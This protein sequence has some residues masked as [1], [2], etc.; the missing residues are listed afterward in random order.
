MFLLNSALI[1]SVTSY[2]ARSKFLVP[3]HDA[4]LRFTLIHS[5]Q[6]QIMRSMMPETRVQPH[7]TI[8]HYNP[9]SRQHLACCIYGLLF[10]FRKHFL[11]V[12]RRKLAFTDKEFPPM[13]R[14]QFTTYRP[15]TPCLEIFSK[16]RTSTTSQ[17]LRLRIE[18]ELLQFHSSHRPTTFKDVSRDIHY[19]CHVSPPPHIYQSRSAFLDRYDVQFDRRRCSGHLTTTK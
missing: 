7:P 1:P 9:F 4:I 17:R 2:A 10:F 11:T 6:Y 5:P 15:A 14:I 18:R 19:S 13:L 16:E 12:V 8:T 3:I